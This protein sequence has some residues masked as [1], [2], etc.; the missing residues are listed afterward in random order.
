[1]FKIAAIEL[2]QNFRAALDAHWRGL[3]GLAFMVL[4]M[5]SIQYDEHLAPELNRLNDGISHV[6]TN[7]SNK[8]AS[9]TL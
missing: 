2:K 3:A 9:F 6:A 4:A 1:M 7:F 8:L 5:V